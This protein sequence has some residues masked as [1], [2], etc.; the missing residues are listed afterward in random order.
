ML[1]SY[2]QTARSQNI[3][4]CDPGI[5]CE[6]DCTIHNNTFTFVERNQGIHV[7]PFRYVFDLN[8]CRSKDRI[9]A[10]GFRQ[11]HGWPMLKTFP[12]RKPWRGSFFSLLGD[13]TLP[14]AASDGYGHCII[15]W[16]LRWRH[17]NGGTSRLQESRSSEF[18][19]HL[20][21]S[22]L[23]TLM[24][25]MAFWVYELLVIILRILCISHKPS[26]SVK[27]LIA[28]RWET[29]NPVLLLF[30]SLPRSLPLAALLILLFKHHSGILL[31]CWFDWW[32]ALVSILANQFVPF[33]RTVR[34]HWHLIG[35]KWSLCFVTIE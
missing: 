34:L 28:L 1:N 23:Y 21:E 6:E 18:G 20:A 22:I 16:W 27:Y 2:A 24:R 9:V 31:S 3:D 13:P 12:G 4:F 5:K 26:T 15:D 14:R 33:H 10:N 8:Y 7:L 30:K 17:L 25:L 29:W 35:M 19:K 11:E 32:F